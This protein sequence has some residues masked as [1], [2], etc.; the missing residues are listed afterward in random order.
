MIIALSVF[1]LVFDPSVKYQ[2]LFAL[3]DLTSE[4]SLIGQLDI[5]GAFNPVVL[6][7]VLALVM[8]A[9]FDATGTIRAVAGQSEFCSIKT[10]ILSAAAEP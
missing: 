7:I 5:M 2:G 6:P 1:G 3:P 4:H 8:T 9:I 10:T